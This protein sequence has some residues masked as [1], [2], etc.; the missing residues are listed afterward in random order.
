MLH[1]K[2]LW[3]DEF[4]LGSFYQKKG[5]MSLIAKGAKNP[6]SKFFGYL[7]PFCKLNVTYSGRSDLKN[8]LVLIVT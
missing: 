1:P 4:N 3:G 5:K 2:I 6:K 8:L 7:G